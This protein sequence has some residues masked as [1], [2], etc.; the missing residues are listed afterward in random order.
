MGCRLR[1][2][3]KLLPT[4]VKL[5]ASN[6]RA[7]RVGLLQHIDQFGESLS[8]QIVDEQVFPHVAT[9]FSY[10]S[11]FLRVLTLKSML[12]LAPKVDEEPSTRTNTTTLQPTKHTTMKDI[13]TENFQRIRDACEISSD[14]RKCL[15]YDIYGM[16]GLTSGLELGP[17]LNKPEEIKEELERLRRRK[18][19]EKASVHAR[20]SGSLLVNLSLPQF[21]NRG[22]ILRGTVPQEQ[23]CRH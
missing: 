2:P 16:E 8:T 12:V 19:E 22:G 20:P 21:V 11:A 9:G 18:E 13:A 1:N 6:D 4:I 7:I 17:K 23:N 10:T 3:T 5:F 15:I 14:E